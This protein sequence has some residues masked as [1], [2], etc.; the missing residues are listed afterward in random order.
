[1]PRKAVKHRRKK[2]VKT[3]S[4]QEALL[5]QMIQ[6]LG[7]KTKL[8][9]LTLA[10]WKAEKA[11]RLPKPSAAGDSGIIRVPLDQLDDSP[12]QLR[13]DMY[14]DELAELT[15]SIHDQGLLNPILVRHV[16]KGWETIFGHRR[17]AAFRR[18]QF[19]AK[20]DAE[21]EKYDAIPAR[22]LDSVTD[23]QVLLLGLAENMFRADI[24]PLDA[25]LGL[26]TLRKLKPSLNT[27]EKLAEVT[28]LQ[29]KKVKRLLQLAASP[30]VVQKGVSDGIKV[31]VDP[32]QKDGGDGDE[33][34]EETRKLD[35]LSALQFA[36][37]YQALSKKGDK[38]KGGKSKAEAQTG[39]AIARALKE[40]WGLRDVTL[41][42]SKAI[43]S[44]TAPKKGPGRP[45][46]PF[47]KTARQLVIYYGQLDALTDIQAQSLRKALQE[48]IEKLDARPKGTAL[49]RRAHVRKTA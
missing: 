9:E 10:N 11:S 6:Q 12:Y 26:D 4:N 38:T 32:D 35:L 41:Y 14:E 3:I 20:T 48:V 45:A 23:D 29:P 22:V 25:A 36:R 42:V 49:S 24:S 28:D 17:V 46:V 15:R 19:A 8:A 43:A 47:K 21:K 44:L 37:L 34:T 16:E 1:M 33:A 13:R 40:N 7:P 30:D 31:P 39:A 2:R 27:A 5:R 18:L